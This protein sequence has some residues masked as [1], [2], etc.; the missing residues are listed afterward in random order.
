M[1]SY[2][3]LPM[4][5]VARKSL[6]T[7]YSGEKETSVGL[8]PRGKHTPGTQVAIRPALGAVLYIALYTKKLK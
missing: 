1:R 4:W 6:F 7:C 5:I 2:L 3:H 8:F